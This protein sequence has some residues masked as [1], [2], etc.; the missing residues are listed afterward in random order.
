MFYILSTIY[1]VTLVLISLFFGDQYYE[2]ALKIGEF[3]QYTC[4]FVCIGSYVLNPSYRKGSL[5]LF[6]AF[7]EYYGFIGDRIFHN[8]NATY[9]LLES[10]VFLIFGMYITFHPKRKTAKTIDHNNILLAFYK[11][12]KGSLIMRVSSLFGYNVKSMCILAGE[13][14]LYLKSNKPGFIFGN[15]LKIHRKSDDYTIVDTGKPYTEEFIR[16][17]K[18]HHNAIATKGKFRVRCIDGVSDLLGMIGEEFKPKSYIP[19]V[20]LRKI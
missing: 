9:Y 8:T 14:A 1:L 6:L 2:I 16:E 13:N 18:K 15:S 5:L 7:L 3:I 4:I 20:Y 11:G 10:L 17:M 12:K 19:S